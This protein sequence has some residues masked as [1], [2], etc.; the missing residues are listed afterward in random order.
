M[1]A[2]RCARADLLLVDG[3]PLEDLSLLEGQGKHLALVA[4]GGEILI[5]RLD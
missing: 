5:N 4:R 2:P 1:I 3:N